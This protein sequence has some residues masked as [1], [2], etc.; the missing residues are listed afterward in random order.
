MVN[1]DLN[2]FSLNVELFGWGTGS[3]L[4]FALAT[5]PAAAQTVSYINLLQFDLVSYRSQ[6]TSGMLDDDIEKVSSAARLLE[7]GHDKVNVNGG[8]VA[9][10]HPLGASGARIVVTLINAL[11]QRGLKKGVASLCIGGGQGMAMV[12]ENI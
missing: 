1:A 3:L 5:A 2:G 12:L 9:L 10:G 7:I 11:R 4:L 8:A 6:A